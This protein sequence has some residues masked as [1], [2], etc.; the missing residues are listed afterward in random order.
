[1]ERELPGL[2]AA[3]KALDYSLNYWAALTCHL[4]GGEVPIDGN[5]LRASDQA[6]DSD[7]PAQR[8]AIV[9]SLVPSSKLNGHDPHA[10]LKDALQ[11]LPSHP[12]SRIYCSAGAGKGVPSAA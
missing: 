5:F 4:K 7:W 10:Y 2:N 8:A 6:L 3:V 12:A 1:V 9:M 11:R